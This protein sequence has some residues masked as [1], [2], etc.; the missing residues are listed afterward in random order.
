MSDRKS[1][2]KPIDGVIIPV[3]PNIADVPDGYMDPESVKHKR[4][5]S[6]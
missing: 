3:A 1:M 4:L 2:G 6:G 5:N